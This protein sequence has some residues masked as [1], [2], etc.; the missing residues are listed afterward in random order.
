[1]KPKSLGAVAVW[2]LIVAAGAFLS[3]VAIA[4]A[5]KLEVTQ[6]EPTGSMPKAVTVS[7]DGKHLVVTN[8]G[9]WGHH[10]LFWYDPVTL[11]RIDE[12]HFNPTV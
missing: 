10:N 2:G 5:P 9:Q 11:K 6:M 7:P 1:M 4:K 8:F 3:S 12:T